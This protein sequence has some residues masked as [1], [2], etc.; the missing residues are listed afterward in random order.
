MATKEGTQLYYKKPSIKNNKGE[1]WDRQWV[2]HKANK[3]KRK[4]VWH[5]VETRNGVKKV[6]RTRT[7]VATIGGNIGSKIKEL[8]KKGQENEKANSEALKLKIKTKKEQGFVYK[9]GK[10]IKD[11][12]ATKKSYAKDRV[13]Y[14]DKNSKEYKDAVKMT[15]KNKLKINNNEEVS[16]ENKNKNNEIKVD[17]KTAFNQDKS[18][19]DNKNEKKTEKKTEKKKSKWIK[20]RNGTLAKRGSITARGAERREK[21]REKAQAAAKLRIKKKKE[22]QK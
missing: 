11:P 17:T 2:L 12:N 3:D 14:V 13:G 15:N 16:K 20:R 5:L 7:G 10:W 19:L 22:Q 18:L 9:N 21:A 6:V 1:T 4:Q 8:W